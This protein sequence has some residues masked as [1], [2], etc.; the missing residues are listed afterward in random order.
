MSQ[1]PDSQKL[2]GAMIYLLA[3]RTGKSA[4]TGFLGKIK[5]QEIDFA[6]SSVLPKGFLPTP[7]AYLLRESQRGADANKEK[8]AYENIKEFDYLSEAQIKELV[9]NPKKLYG[10]IICDTIDH[11]HLETNQ[12]V[13]VNTLN[14]N[15][16]DNLIFSVQ[17]TV[18]AHGDEAI[19]EFEFFLRTDDHVIP[20]LLEEQLHHVFH[21]GKRSSQGY[22][23]FELTGF[24]PITVKTPVNSKHSFLNL[25]ML[26][27]GQIEYNAPTALTLFSSERRPYAGKETGWIKAEN[28]GHFISFIAPGSVIVLPQAKGSWEER[29]QKVGKS[30]DAPT[31]SEGEIVFGNAFLYPLEVK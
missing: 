16:G 9:H 10:E 8:A 19:K 18:C 20:N 17:Q 11:I 1:V 12:Q 6:L 22:N 15:G 26:L 29:L 4:A 14:Q 21:L 2:F 3:D 13:H 27:P 25:G 7:K 31:A 30:I 23:L 24:V 28:C 5:A